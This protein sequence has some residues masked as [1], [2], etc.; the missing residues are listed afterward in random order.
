MPN[1]TPT[2]IQG[3]ILGVVIWCWFF[4][5]TPERALRAG[6]VLQDP[7]LYFRMAGF[8]LLRM[9]AFFGCAAMGFFLPLEY[10]LMNLDAPTIA[11]DT[12]QGVYPGP[13]L[14]IGLTLLLLF[15]IP[16]AVT[17]TRQRRDDH[18][19]EWL[20][21]SLVFYRWFWLGVVLLACVGWPALL[22][23]GTPLNETFG[24]ALPLIATILFFLW[25][26]LPSWAVASLA[27]KAEPIA[28]DALAGV[29]LWGLP[30]YL[31]FII[32]RS[33]QKKRFARG[34]GTSQKLCPS[35]MRPID[36]VEFYESL[37]FEAC[38]HC[39]E[40]IPPI[41]QITDYIEHYS[42]R[43]TE[44]AEARQ[45]ETKGRKAREADRFEHD[46]IQRIMRAAL[47]MAVRERGT[48]LHLVTEGG[49]FLLRCRT[50]GVLFTMLDFPDI[51][52][53]SMI[54][55]VKVQCNLDI[56]ERRK[57]QDGSW[58]SIVDGKKLDVRV[59]TSP[60]PAGETA[61]LR[62]LYEQRVLGSLDHLG[63]TSRSLRVLQEVI[64]RPHGLILV[65]GPTGSGKSTT[66]YN[67]LGTIADGKRNII[68]LEDPIEFKIEG[69]TQMQVDASKNFG[70]ASGLRTI[71]RQD[72]DV[73]MVGEI[74]DGETAKM[75]IDAAMTGHLVFSTLHTIDTT[76]T[77][78]RLSDLGVDPHRHAEALLLLIA[79]RLVRL[80]CKEC[81][82]DYEVTAE[83]LA[84]MGMDGGPAKLVLKRGEGCD[85]CH[86]TGYFERSGIYELLEPDS[87]IRAM[88][89]QR[90]APGELRKA[91]REHGM[92]TLLEDG[93]VKVLLGKTTVDEILRVTS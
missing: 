72:P 65:T 10:D 56:S 27:E 11:S 2:Q 75:A 17:W 5:L 83:E 15:I 31:M 90:I 13:L 12:F 1:F 64:V 51:L 89:G 66:L 28:I 88:M 43:A 60:T 24:L 37:D 92:R 35:C 85:I 68:T 26:A 70:F 57:P 61:S 78:G 22:G 81:T 30:K 6:I 41:F 93:M 86:H 74:R 18:P 52:Q 23:M 67:S 47:T 55:A 87:E 45:T 73:I 48:D 29:R 79:Q 21:V 8:K 19:G 34:D 77:I 82:R 62:L 76:T 50:D 91:A 3:V 38:P 39:K 40:V 49:R 36:Q 20:T 9:L 69:L 80:N 14:A 84:V 54:S 42:Q 16:T 71:L 7:P 4:L 32:S 33:S 58:K 25:W 46:V 59:N 53:R 44:I 63:M